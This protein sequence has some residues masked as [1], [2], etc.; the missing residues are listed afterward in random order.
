MEICVIHGSHRKG[1]TDKTIE[2]IKTQLDSFENI[3]Y[4]DIFLHNDLPHFCNG[5]FACLSTGDYAGQ[6]CPHKQYTHPIKEKLLR[7]DGI[8][9]GSPSYALSETAQVKALFD[10]FACTYIIHRPN[11]EMFN[12]IGFVVSTAAGAGTKRVI[13]TVSR[14]LLFWGIKR[15]IKCGINMWEKNWNN[16]PQKKRLKEEKKL[17]SKARKFYKLIKNRYKVRPNMAVNVLRLIAKKLI[18]SYKDMEP[19]KKYWKSKGWL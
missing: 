18:N 12:K 15:I 7:S 4:S 17:K 14:N 16:M 3:S 11:E 1:N 5:C 10:H 13:S 6:N 8:I 2:I 9:I 19:D